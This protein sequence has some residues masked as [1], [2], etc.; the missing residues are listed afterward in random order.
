MITSVRFDGAQRATQ[1]GKTLRALK[2]V[3]SEAVLE[4]LAGN[5]ATICNNLSAGV[6]SQN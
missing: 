1:Q 3:S 4:A 6:S 2:K 5:S